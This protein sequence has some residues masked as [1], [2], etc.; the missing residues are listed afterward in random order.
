VAS[1]Q[2]LCQGEHADG[3]E[4]GRSV[5]PDARRFD[6]RMVT[7]TRGPNL[8]LLRS[9]EGWSDH[10]GV[11]VEVKD[12]VGAGDAFTAALAMGLLLEWPLER[13]N[14]AANE[15]ASYVCGFAGAIPAL[16]PPLAAAFATS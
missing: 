3:S 7:M 5:T 15:V 9:T 4:N 11:P 10:G 8:S 13:I 6:L 2:R 12:R 1:R 16:P 14:A